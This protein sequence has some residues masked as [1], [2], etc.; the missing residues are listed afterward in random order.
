MSEENKQTEIIKE[1]LFPIKI[2]KDLLDLKDTKGQNI[3]EKIYS[4]LQKRELITDDKKIDQYINYQNKDEE[5]LFWIIR[6]K[7]SSLEYSKTINID[8]PKMNSYFGK[9]IDEWGGEESHKPPFS[10]KRISEIEKGSEF[11]LK[12]LEDL[13][14]WMVEIEQQS[15]TYDGKAYERCEYALFETINKNTFI[16]AEHV[17]DA[18]SVPLGF[19]K[20]EGTLRNYLSKSYYLY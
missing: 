5:E 14:D 13:K 16:F 10:D 7:A 8:I 20:D 9:W 2:D 19:F 11:T 12:E 18:E 6:D 1:T 17:N 15:I 3:L 4:D